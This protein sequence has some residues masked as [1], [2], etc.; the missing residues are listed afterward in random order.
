VRLAKPDAVVPPERLRVDKGAGH[1]GPCGG[2]VVDPGSDATTKSRSVPSM[3]EITQAITPL[4]VYDDIA[5]AHDFLVEA[6]GLSPGGVTRDSDG[7]AVHGEVSTGP[8]TIW[9]HRVNPE[10]QL[11]SPSSLATQSGGLAVIVPDV[12]AHFDH[13][14]ARGAVIDAP[15]ADQPYGRRE[16]GARDLEGH[17]WWFGTV[18]T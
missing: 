10:D 11:A 16:Y 12:D 9:L 14:S 7:N 8:M 5:A 15:P 1:I 4:L 2:A 13:A 17:R 6:F 18:T 3:P